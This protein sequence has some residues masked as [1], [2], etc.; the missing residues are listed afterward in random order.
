MNLRR[1]IC[2][3]FASFAILGGTSA[4]G[5]VNTWTFN[6]IITTGLPGSPYQANLPYSVYF[7]VDNTWL[8]ATSPGLYFP[9]AGYGFHANSSG[10]GASSQGSGV[11]VA[12][13]QPTGAG[14]S[15]DG[16]IFSM[17]GEQD[18]AFPSGVLFNGSAFGIT[19][20]NPS[21]GPTAT[22]FNG[23]GFPTTLDLNQFSERYMAVY[24]QGG[25]VLGSVDS[26]YIN[27]VLISQV[28]E[29]G[30]FGLLALG[31]LLL[32]GWRV[33]RLVEGE[34]LRPH[35]VHRALEILADPTIVGIWTTTN[36]RWTR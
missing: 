11:L 6:G 9:S 33:W 31:G 17:F 32:S 25:P 34:R 4:R 22:P 20:V 23:T 10:F 14:G 35:L 26:L 16:V 7:D 15:F 8:A 13:D 24:F 19:L 1:V 5:S 27:G 28:P 21:A 12:N 29:P 2:S 30:V 36:P 18:T 3:G